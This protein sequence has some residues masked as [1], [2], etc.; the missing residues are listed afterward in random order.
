MSNVAPVV[1][2]VDDDPSVRRA[3]QRL[4]ESI[5]LQVELFASA[6]EF[7]R[8]KRPDAPSCLVL[9]IRLPGISG[10]DFQ[11]QLAEANIH[12]P[13]IFIT[14]HGDIPMTVRA[15]KAGAVEFLTKPFRD[16]DLLDAIQIALERDRTRR[17]QETEVAMLRARYESLTPREREVMPLVVAGPLLR[18]PRQILGNR[19]S[20]PRE[21]F[22]MPIGRAYPSVNITARR[23]CFSSTP[24][25]LFAHPRSAMNSATSSE[26]RK[27]QL[28]TL[29]VIASNVV[30]NVSLSHGMRQA[31]TIVSAS[32]LDYA[33]AFANP[34]AVAGVLVLALWMITDLALLSRADLSF[35]LPVT[36]SAYVLIALA[37][38]FLL[39]ERISAQRWVAIVVITLGVVLAEETPPRTTEGPPDHLLG[40]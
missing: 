16:Q 27:T 4:V 18:I 2:V 15:M 32:L 13:I 20:R 24:D 31:V 37:G 5:G 14:A 21:A 25:M 8:S 17:V 33:R 36:A 19:R 29:V 7:L 34:W 30:G 35:V 22:S 40:G 1:F 38:H 12:I 26:V 11:R 6:Q 28:L 9:D 10:L 3:I 23:L 39:H